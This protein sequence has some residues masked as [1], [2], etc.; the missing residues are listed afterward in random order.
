MIHEDQIFVVNVVVTNLTQK[1]VAMSVI[2][3]LTSVVVGLTTIA[4]IRKYKR[5]NEGHHFMPMVI[6]RCMR[7]LG[8]IWIV[9]SRSV[10]I[11]FTITDQ[12]VI[13]PCFFVFKF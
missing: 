12:E 11:F 1:M 9:S 3:R 13:Y 5:F 4:N 7:H 6:M 8:V 10:F 2:N